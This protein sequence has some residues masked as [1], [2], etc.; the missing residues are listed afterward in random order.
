MS[1]PMPPPA[2]AARVDSAVEGGRHYVTLLF[3][4]LSRSTELAGAMEAEQYAALLSTLRIA[5][6]ETVPRWGG[7]IV[8]VQGDGLLAMFGH[9]VTH[10]HAGRR[11]VEAALA[12]HQAV[13]RLAPRLPAGFA[14]QLH[15]G[16][17]AGLV[18]IS[19]GDIERGR[20]ELI[21]TVPN[22]AARLSDA[23]G[24]HEIVV[25]DETLGPARRFFGAGAPSMLSVK[26][27][28]APILVY[29]IEARAETAAGAQ[30][31]GRHA[32]ADRRPPDRVRAPCAGAGHGVRR[33][34]CG[35]GGGRAARHR[36]DAPGRR[37]PAPRAPV[38]LPR[39]AR[40]LR[41]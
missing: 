37:V 23:A 1:G 27:R 20:F 8:R 2:T 22:I 32:R 7:T 40:Q 31:R 18:L 9:P 6:Q 26:G 13:R 39:A 29:R 36:Q 17:H 10:E 28:E 3:S 38:R 21:G 41:K 16:I 14:L 35:C 12:L 4:D 19:A 30:A 24:P 15:T 5:Y 34:A 33:P 11:A 25:S